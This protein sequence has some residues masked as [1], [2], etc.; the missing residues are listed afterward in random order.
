MS[1]LNYLEFFDCKL[2]NIVGF[3]YGADSKAIRGCHMTS[4]LHLIVLH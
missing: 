3:L 4:A 2:V 1:L